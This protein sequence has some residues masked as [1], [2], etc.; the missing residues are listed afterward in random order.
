[1]SE[2]AGEKSHAATGKRREEFAAKGQVA[3]SKELMGAIVLACTSYMLLS[4]GGQMGL[5]LVDALRAFLH[6]LRH[7]LDHQ[8]LYAFGG[9]LCWLVLPVAATSA[10]ASVLAALVQNK[11]TLP[12]RE[13]SFDASRLNFLPRLLAMFNPKESGVNT[14][15]SLAKIFT[16]AA[17]FYGVLKAPLQ[18]FVLHV[19]ASLQVGLGEA[20]HIFQRVLVRGVVVMLLFGSLDFALNWYRLEQKMKMSSQELK[21]EAKEAQ[22]DSRIKGRRR[23][24][25]Q[26]LIRRRSLTAV[27]KAD[28]VIVNPTH[29]AVAVRY[30]AEKMQ[31]PV[32]VAKGT[33]A[34]AARIR[35]IARK[36]GVPV[37]SQPPLAR[38]LYA[39]V[40]IGKA[41]PAEVYQAVAVVLAHVYRI[42]GKKAS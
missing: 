11:G 33:D 27:P 17:V 39:E 7:P 40:K 22:G 28:V 30:D 5:V 35:Q 13:V 3:R 37:V 32:V 29:Y 26:D 38:L 6:D 8:L 24:F 12:F 14:L 41:I 23:K 18:A 42:S 4:F 1:M 10:A 19:P 2:Q 16:L 20:N 21:E 31:A 15:I 36:H 25:G 9:R 34:F